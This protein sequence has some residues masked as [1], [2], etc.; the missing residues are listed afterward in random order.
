MGLIA[1]WG[2]KATRFG[3]GFGAL[4]RRM[5]RA[6]M[7]SAY[8][9]WRVGASRNL[10]LALIPQDLRTIDPVRADD[11]HAGLFHFAGRML[12][13]HGRSP[14][15]MPAPSPDFAA[16]LHG[17]LWLRH[18][19]GANAAVYNVHARHLV[20]TWFNEVGASTPAAWTPSVI[21]ARL[22]A[23]LSN[24]GMILE[25]AD[26]SF[27]GRFVQQIVRQA[28]V[29]DR[30]VPTLLPGFE[31]IEALT[32]LTLVG[33]CVNGQERLARSA[34]TR[35]SDELERF[36]L[37]DGAPISRQPGVLIDL[38][39]DLLPLQQ[40]F[41]M[42]ET[43]PPKGLVNAVDRMMPALRF[44]RGGDGSLAVFNGMGPSEA[45]LIATIL[46]YDD[47][48][49]QVPSSAPYSG[50]ARLAKG[51]AL[52]I[53]D[54]GSPPPR[55]YSREAHAGT[56]A[57]QFWFGTAPVVVNCG[58]PQWSREQ[59]REV[60]RVTAAHSTLVIDDTSSAL[61][62]KPFVGETGSVILKGP[63]KVRLDVAPEGDALEA[64]HDGYVPAFGLVHERAIRLE[65]DGAAM[66][67]EDR[68]TGAER[69]VPYVLR[70]HLHPSIQ[71]VVAEG[72]RSV[73]L[74]LNAHEAFVFSA[75]ARCTVEDSVFLAGSGGAKRCK[76]I[77]VTT[78]RGEQEV[79]HW[80]FDHHE[81]PHRTATAQPEPEL[82][83]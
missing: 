16:I 1:T 22:R 11:I 57:F 5:R 2:R 41:L 51:R 26:A 34:A 74:P 8:G 32:A 65:R 10:T 52:L 56:L 75:D 15:Q 73:I 40:V 27:Y 62:D 44:L 24:A 53:C 67:G 25:G 14:F 61:F 82:P 63:R 48:M 38:L 3:A 71:P 68:L 39:I 6:R 49:G 50:Y 45:D 66:V 20:E 69:D 43:T 23:F 47:G 55:A 4:R 58:L 29:L 21:A 64:S 72:H 37:P 81:R 31:R 7:V 80:R 36:V 59:W 76:Q 79:V 70:F 78:T 42:S 19:R 46:R 28:K 30:L 18:L 9:L 83:L 13:T 17:F 60:V 54:A 35:L 12:D 77:V 33:L